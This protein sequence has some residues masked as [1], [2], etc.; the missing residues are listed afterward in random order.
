MRS[1]VVVCIL[2]GCGM[3]EAFKQK[4]TPT[5]KRTTVLAANT[6]ANQESYIEY[7]STISDLPQGFSSH[8]PNTFTNAAY[9]NRF[10]SNQPNTSSNQPITRLLFSVRYNPIN[11][12]LSIPLPPLPLSFK[13]ILG[14]QFT[15]QF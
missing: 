15:L 13:R 4:R 9:K 1:L 14:W 2:L 12:A 11:T 8:Q 3:V 7:L 5:M 10:S 6:F